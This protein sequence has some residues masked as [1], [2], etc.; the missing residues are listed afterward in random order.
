MRDA[1]DLQED[2]HDN[3]FLTSVRKEAG[4][5]YKRNVHSQAATTNLLASITTWWED[6]ADR[7]RQ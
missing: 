2:D 7:N 6:K 1:K 3:E 5:F 4:Q